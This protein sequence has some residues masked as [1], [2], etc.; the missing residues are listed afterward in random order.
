V[1]WKASAGDPRLF[2]RSLPAPSDIEAKT[3]WVDPAVEAVMKESNPAR[4]VPTSLRVVDRRE[5]AHVLIVRGAA[6]PGGRNQVVAHLRVCLVT[7]P[8]HSC[9]HLARHCSGRPRC[10]CLEL[11]SSRT[12]S[13]QLT[14]A[15]WTSSSQRGLCY[16]KEA[17]RWRTFVG[18]TD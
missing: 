4:R 8:E 14:R 13:A 17:S 16:G 7:T 15:W 6:K 5:L 18:A 3:V 1:L 11:S 2:I 9:R 12:L 10:M